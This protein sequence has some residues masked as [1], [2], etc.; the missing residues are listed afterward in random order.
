MV[1]MDPDGMVSSA[2]TIFNSEIRNIMT[3]QNFL[4]LHNP[5]TPAERIYESGPKVLTEY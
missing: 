4:S 2:S 3:V 1:G 5:Y